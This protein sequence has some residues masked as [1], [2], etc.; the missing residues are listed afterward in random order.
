MEKRYARIYIFFCNFLSQ[1]SKKNIE[2]EKV[3]QHGPGCDEGLI[4]LLTLALT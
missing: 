2:K 1:P 3:S 4:D